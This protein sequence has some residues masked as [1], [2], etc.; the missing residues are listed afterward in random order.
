MAYYRL[1]EKELRAYCET[2]M[3]K[4][5]FN[6]KQSR[7]IAD[8][9]LTADLQGLESHGVQRLIRYH[10]GVKSGVIRPDAVPEVVHETPLSVVLDAH[11]AMGQI[12]AVDAMERAIAKAKQYGFGAA[13][14]RNSNHFG[15]GGYYAMMAEREDMLGMC[16][17]NTQAICVPT[18]GREVMLGTNPIAFA[19]PADPI[20]ML[21]DVATTVVPR[22]KL[23]VYAKQGKPMPLGWAVDENG[24]DTTDAKRVIDNINSKAGGGILPLGGS[25]P[26]TGSHKGYGL[27]LIV[28]ILSSII[29]G[30]ATSNHVSKNG[31]GDT[32]Q[33]FFALDYG[34]FRDKAAMRES[35][36]TLL[37]ELRD[38]ANAEG[39][40]RIYTSGEMEVD[41]RSE[42]LKNGIPVN[43]STLAELRTVGSEL[44][45]DF[46]AMVSVRAA[47]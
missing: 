43:D 18:F 32:S 20:P 25:S 2:V 4:Y 37:Q 15:V 28:E 13:V 5:G 30:G 44:G 26:A 6:E 38:S 22:G 27:A 39:R 19:M 3:G 29:A 11:S 10:R 36:S 9:L 7:D 17:T 8:I 23:E 45:L 40:T 14:V 41:S 47:E 31:L 42:K 46:D 21:Y 33:S 1:P 12:A 24:R 34:L 16:F 35:L